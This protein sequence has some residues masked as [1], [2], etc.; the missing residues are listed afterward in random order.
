MTRADWGLP[1]SWKLIEGWCRKPFTYG[2]PLDN[3][4]TKTSKYDHVDFSKPGTADFWASFPSRAIPEKVST[5]IDVDWLEAEIESLEA[6]MT[7]HE[8]DMAHKAIR[9][10]RVG[11]PAY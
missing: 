4:G 8:R 10:L 3:H 1:S 9:Q 5:I 2:R 7:E 11:A 6:S